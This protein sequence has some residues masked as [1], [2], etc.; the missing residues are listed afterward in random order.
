MTIDIKALADRYKISE[1]KVQETIN[2]YKAKVKKELGSVYSGEKLDTEVDKIVTSNV[3]NLFKL[4]GLEL[5]KAEAEAGRAHVIDCV[6]IGVSPAEDKN[7]FKKKDIRKWYYRYLNGGK[8]KEQDKETGEWIEKDH[9]PDLEKINS[10]IVNKKIKLAKSDKGADYPIALEDERVIKFKDENGQAVERE[11][12]KYGQEIDTVFRVK[13]Q[14]IVTAVD[15]KD[16]DPEIVIANMPWPKY[17]DQYGKPKPVSKLND[18]NRMP[19]IGYKS[20]VYAKKFGTAW[21]IMTDGYED[22]G[23]YD[24]AYSSA[25]SLIV[26]DETYMDLPSLDDASPYTS[27]ITKGSVQQIKFDETNTKVSIRVNDIDLPTGINMS[28]RYVP[29]IDAGENLNVSDDVIA[30]GRKLS[31]SK[32]NADGVK[33]TLPFYQLWGIIRNKEEEHDKA[34]EILRNAGLI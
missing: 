11:N 29:I 32:E 28:S 2:G 10:W 25:M 14:M 12:P 4:E 16:V 21:S 23:P 9:A 7:D 6:I 17:I 27:F 15:K 19:K 26:N 20:R 13:V 1:A 30:I 3:N 34:L 5:A 24:G 33:E 22:F 18:V 31:F 8:W